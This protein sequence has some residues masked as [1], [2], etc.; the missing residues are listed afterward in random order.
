MGDIIEIQAGSSASIPTM[1]DGSHL[2]GWP[3]ARFGK[4]PELNVDTP[5]LEF[6]T[7]LR[8]ID[9]CNSPNFLPQSDKLVPEK[10]VCPLLLCW[11]AQKISDDGHEYLLLPPTANPKDGSPSDPT[12]WIDDAG[13]TYP[14]DRIFI[15]K[16]YEDI[17]RL[18]LEHAASKPTKYGTNMLLSGTSGTGKSFFS[19]Y[20]V[21]RLLHPT[22]GGK[23]PETIVWRHTQ[24]GFGGWMYHLG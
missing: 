18:L 15:R 23:V 13:F 2:K 6:G 3:P 10:L 24:G 22:R 19:R 9:A 12:I 21:W 17:A 1:S 5:K 8:D 11:A 16:S 4:I 14:S 7:F 20:F